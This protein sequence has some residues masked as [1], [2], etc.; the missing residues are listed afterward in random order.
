M[1]LEFHIYDFI[2]CIACSLVTLK[3]SVFV[4]SYISLQ[5]IVE[6]EN[7]YIT[8]SRLDTAIICSS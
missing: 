5:K 1:L 3:A 7:L 8:L 4:P 6:V 2:N